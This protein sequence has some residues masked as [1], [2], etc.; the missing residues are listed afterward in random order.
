MTTTASFTGPDR[1]RTYSRGLLGVVFFLLFASHVALPCVIAS[2]S[3]P[4]MTSAAMCQEPMMM[5]SP[6]DTNGLFKIPLPE[7]VPLAGVAFAAAVLI[8]FLPAD[9]KAPT[10]ITALWR[11]FPRFRARGRPF[12][13]MRSGFLPHFAAQRDA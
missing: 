8:L 4:R 9:R 5:K 10:A 12:S 3:G 1:M 2:D 6:S 7:P 11:L 13:T